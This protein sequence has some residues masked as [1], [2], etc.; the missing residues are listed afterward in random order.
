MASARVRTVLIGLGVSMLF[1]LVL[2]A[3]SLVALSRGTLTVAGLGAGIGSADEV[4]YFA[5]MRDIADGNSRM[6][7][8]SFQEYQDA[9]SLAGYALLPQG[10]LARLTGWRI[11]VIVLLGDVLFPALLTF[12]CFLLARI[13]IGGYLIPLLFAVAYM[14]W[15]G[16]GWLRSMNPQITMLLFMLS[17]LAFFRDPDVKRPWVR[18]LL[19]GLFFL[20]QPIYGVLMLAAEGTDAL[21]AWHRER[22]FMSVVRRR[23]SILLC[24]LVALL[25][26]FWLQSGADAS[27]L[28]DT[29]R[30][31]GLI[32]S[33][34]PTA[35]GLQVLL[36]GALA[37]LLLRSKCR[38]PPFVRGLA[39]ILFCSI[40]VLNQSLF[41]GKDA[42]FALYYRLPLVLVLWLTVLSLASSV[43]SRRILAQL[44]I[45]VALVMLAQMLHLMLT[46]SIPK[47]FVESRHFLGSD[48]SEILSKL[49]EGGA[50]KVVLAPIE[51]SNLVPVLTPH[52]TL[53]TQ[54]AHYEYSSDRELA[55]RYLLLTSIFPLESQYTVEGEPLVF[56]IYAGNMY[57]RAKILCRWGLRQDGCSG[58]LSDFISRQDV[59][60]F[61]EEG[62]I[63]QKALLEKYGVTTI[64]S[65]RPLP[66]EIDQLCTQSASAGRFS[67]YDC[68]F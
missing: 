65:E 15:W 61:V 52:H 48:V 32:D 33:H 40:V 16:P 55:E 12:V 28:L 45:V 62:K 27:I 49:G 37:L 1:S 19:L 26:Q 13:F 42:V 24:L 2:N 47:S 36:L 39:I 10:L 22:S 66:Q 17:I 6:G 58:T 43:L 20:T 18:G 57:A 56:G 68:V 63:D 35:P 23:T 53:F 7:N 64:V 50:S 54:Y 14:A 25:L 46:V 8:V 34:L 31:R 21:L 51:L 59:R 30:R 38:P 4:Y 44:G 5:L 3:G 41:H 67:I 9:P 11:E 29:Y 60:R